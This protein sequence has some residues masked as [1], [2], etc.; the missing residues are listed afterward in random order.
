MV[1]GAAVE[2]AGLEPLLDAALLAFDGDAM[3]AGHHRRERLG[4]AHA[5]EPGGQDPACR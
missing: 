3:G 5:A 4:A 1:V 2:I